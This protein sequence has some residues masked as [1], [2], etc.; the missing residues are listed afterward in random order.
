VAQ[1]L[2]LFVK[3]IRKMTRALQEVQKADIESTLPRE[4]SASHILPPS[5]STSNGGG[6]EIAKELQEEG[7][8][9][10]KALKEQQRE[11]VDSLDLKS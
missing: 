9:V 8:A 3:T 10:L 5:G 1:S 7:D 4:A 11:V 2:A 6:K